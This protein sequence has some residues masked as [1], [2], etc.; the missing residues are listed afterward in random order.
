M[1]I[2]IKRAITNSLSLAHR[3]PKLILKLNHHARIQILKFWGNSL[4]S[5]IVG[6]R[7]DLIKI[8]NRVILAH[9]SLNL[10]LA[11]LYSLQNSSLSLVI[12]CF[13]LINHFSYLSAHRSPNWS[14][15]FHSFIIYYVYVMNSSKIKLL[16]FFKK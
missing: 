10:T 13:S 3:A 16:V 12:F 7:R 15:N 11:L 2:I 8:Y 5:E 4:T 14:K 9:I 1:H 6:M